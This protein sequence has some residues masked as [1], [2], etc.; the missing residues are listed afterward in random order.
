MKKENP[1]ELAASAGK[2]CAA[3]EVVPQTS[4]ATSEVAAEVGGTD[5][6]GIAAIEVVPQTSEATSEVAA[7][8]RGT[9]V[10]GIAAIEVVSQTSE[11]T[12]EG[13]ESGPQ[14]KVAAPSL[15]A[16][17]AKWAAKRTS[18]GSS[19]GAPLSSDE[20]QVETPANGLAIDNFEREVD[21]EGDVRAT[22][23]AVHSAEHD[24]ELHPSLERLLEAID[25]AGI[26]EDEAHTLIDRATD[27]DGRI[28][29]EHANEL[30]EI[31]ITAQR[32]ESEINGMDVDDL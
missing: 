28:N 9:D 21:N 12:S 31:H 30:L 20:K 24:D 3:I 25:A 26:S 6:P 22:G 18:K 5:V 7:K 15:E 1:A 14:S 11:A 10:P 4:E 19:S 2:G 29:T 32:A 8:V 13:I 23:G 17:K 16:L 27:S